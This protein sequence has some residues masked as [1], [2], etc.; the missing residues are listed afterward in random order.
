MTD[1]RSTGTT[2]IQLENIALRLNIEG[3]REVFMRDSLPKSRLICQECGIVNLDTN[4][5]RG[6]HWTCWFV[7][8]QGKNLL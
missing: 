7:S 4:S 5:G 1:Q 3:F 6:T 8:E 2:N